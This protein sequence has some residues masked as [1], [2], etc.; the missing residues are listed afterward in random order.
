MIKIG[1][2]G[3]GTI[4]SALVRGFCTDRKRSGECRFFLS[5]RNAEKAAALA[6]AF[7]GLVTVCSNNQEAVDRSEWV[8]LT[9]LPPQGREVLT[10]LTFRPEH[11]ILTIMSDHSVTRVR[12][13]TGPVS[14][15]IRM[16]PLPF[17]A[18]HIGPIAVYPH[19]PET[20][21]LFA[22]LGNV[23]PVERENELSVISAETAVMSAF[24]HLIYDTV[25]WGEEH[26]LPKEASLEYMTSFFEALSV[27]ARNAEN[28]DV[29]ALA[30]EMT[31]GGLNETALKAILGRDGFG[32]WREALDI[33]WERLMKG[34]AR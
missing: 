2:L 17:A 9:V 5:P 11:K 10:S 27:K 8:F 34:S 32:I 6:E 20:E 25:S 33:I 29:Y 15:I 12:E 22:P 30:Y 4:S 16:V 7:P 18:M 21:E 23:I 19:D 26:G 14:K 1:I 24:Y 3:T 28:G 13:W 31:P